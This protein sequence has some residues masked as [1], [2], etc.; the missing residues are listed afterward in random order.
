MDN[1][2]ETRFI[3]DINSPFPFIEHQA[4]KTRVFEFD[5]IKIFD[6]HFPLSKWKHFA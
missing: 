4:F 6:Y 3:Q 5:S 2:E 1:I